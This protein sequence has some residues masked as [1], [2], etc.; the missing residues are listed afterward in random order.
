MTENISS[1]IEIGKNIE[2]E[3]NKDVDSS[4]FLKSNVLETFK[5]NVIS[6]TSPIYKG[7]I[8]PI[9]QGDNVKIIFYKKDT[10]KFYFLGE[11]IKRQ[12]KDNLYI[13]YIAC[14][15]KI[16]KDQRRNY[17]RLNTLLSIKINILNGDIEKESIPCLARDI[18]GGG[19]GIIC[20]EKIPYGT[21]VKCI[22]PLD[23]SVVNSIGKVVR[24]KA[25]PDSIIKYDIGIEFETLD[26][27]IRT[28]IISF[29]F[30]KQRK[31]RKKG[32][33]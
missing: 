7:N 1:I 12:K 32:L 5:N 21:M 6:I 9:S 3:I 17:Y 19:L 23:D 26:E 4:I 22:I 18:S 13:L 24:C 27:T 33:I 11:V 31:L 8:Y 29:I 25:V 16:R 28:Q 15:S 10:G 30:N 2:I 20:K 14:N